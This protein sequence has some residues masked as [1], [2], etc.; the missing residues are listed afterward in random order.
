[1]IRLPVLLIA[2]CVIAA[3]ALARPADSPPVPELPPPGASAFRL[4]TIVPRPPGSLPVAP[5]GFVVEPWAGPLDAPRKLLVLPNGDVL[6]AQARTER[7]GGMADEVV[8]MLAERGIFGPSP[9]RVTL[10]RETPQGT[11]ALPLLEGL[12]Q[13]FGLLLHEGWLYVANTDSLVRVRYTPGHDQVQ[14]TL[15]TVLALPAQAP[16]NHWTRNLALAADGRTLL[17]TV[18][19]ATN[20][21]EDSSEP[22]ERAAIWSVDPDTGTYRLLAT[23]L[24]NPVGLDFEPASG[25]LW[26]TVNERDGLGE[27]VPPDYLTAVV[28]GA[29][30]GWPW[31]YFGSYPDPVLNAREPARVAAAAA[32]AR[33]PDLALDAHSVPLGLRFYRG[34]AFPARF[35][36]GAFV[37]RRGSVGRSE[38]RGYDLL[39]IPFAGGRPSGPPEPFLAGFIADPAAG[40]V[41]G[42]PVYVAETAD[43]ALLLSDDA[44]GMIWRVRHAGAT[45]GLDSL[46]LR[47][48]YGGRAGLA[49]QR[50]Q[51]V[52][53]IVVNVRRLGGIQRWQEELGN[54]HPDLAWLRIGDIDEPGPVDL[55]RVADTLRR[56]VPPGVPVLMDPERHWARGLDLD[57]AQP[58][59]LLFG[60][61]GQLAGQ[62]RGRWNAELGTG[63]AAAL[64]ALSA[65]Q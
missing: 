51:P 5:E 25:V 21:N 65:T 53:V 7:M 32:S 6:V 56:R 49:G 20:A 55:D 39:H 36:G 45:T 15:E 50:G 11:V 43:G 16:N 54:A 62:W 13:P 24:R 44:A 12:N 30:F 22:P 59:V 35:H 42:R 27:E 19:A 40:T 63:F 26:T 57:T 4:P 60:A 23:G 48:Q 8:A 58:T 61:D 2:G 37:A 41:Y 31:V 47:D 17:V 28:A 10:L 3:G 9:N 64:R 34:A 18:G 38:L 33:V 46:E 14:G 52:A 1:M 29:D